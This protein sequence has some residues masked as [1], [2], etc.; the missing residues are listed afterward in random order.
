MKEFFEKFGLTEIL[1]HLFPGFIALCAILLWGL[2][3]PTEWFGAELGKNDF[4]LGVVAL[5]LAYATGL[6]LSMWSVAGLHA[7]RIPP[8]FPGFTWR[9]RLQWL[10]SW[11]KWRLLNLSAGVPLPVPA[12]MVATTEVYDL[13][14]GLYGR[15]AMPLLVYPTTQLS[16]FRSV[17]TDRVREKAETVLHDAGLQRSRFMF[18]LGVALALIVFTISAIVRLVVE[19]IAL[20]PRAQLEA[21]ASWRAA[22]S[23][24]LLGGLAAACAI[25]AQPIR[26]KSPRAGVALWFSAAVCFFGM[27][28]A[29]VWGL[30]PF[31]AFPRLDISFL[32]AI[33][34]SAVAL[35]VCFALQAQQPLGTPLLTL[36]LSANAALVGAAIANLPLLWLWNSSTWARAHHFAVW[37]LVALAGAALYI[38]L[39]LRSVAAYCW[40][41]EVAQTLCIVRLFGHY[42]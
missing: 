17:V 31:R 2:P 42:F 8:T 27:A 34:L 21:G 1:S 14:T 10:G 28:A 22:T 5:I 15:P 13:L 3:Q 6:V 36:F 38:S 39:S 7:A 37:E 41:R 29:R 23:F 33:V 35:A 16:T 18:A 20:I 9:D 32:A 4:V 26:S 25:A 12:S 24:V 19:L 40:E 30:A 11:L